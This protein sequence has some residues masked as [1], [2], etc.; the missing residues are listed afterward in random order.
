VTSDLDPAGA[1]KITEPDCLEFGASTMVRTFSRFWRDENRGQRRNSPPVN[2]NTPS[3]FLFHRSQRG[4]GVE[5]GPGGLAHRVAAANPRGDAVAALAVDETARH[6]PQ[7]IRMR[8][9]RAG[10]GFRLQ[11]AKQFVPLG[12]IADLLIVAARTSGADSDDHGVTPFAVDRGG[13][14]LSAEAARLADE[15]LAARLSFD[16]V[17]TAARL[18]LGQGAAPD[19]PGA[20]RLPDPMRIASG[21]N[22]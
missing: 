7:T 17:E 22:R 1:R 8:A 2:L 12:H 9:E 10:N 14:G 13:A 19:S 5:V 16:G 18:A 11:G 6:R 21:P 3:P 4:H 15:S 20:R